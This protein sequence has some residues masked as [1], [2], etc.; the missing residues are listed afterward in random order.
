[1]NAKR[2]R[3]ALT[4]PGAETNNGDGAEDN[5]ADGYG[6]R[7]IYT[8]RS[9]RKLT[10]RLLMTLLFEHGVSEDEFRVWLDISVDDFAALNPR[11]RYETFKAQLLDYLQTGR[12]Q[13]NE[14]KGAIRAIHAREDFA[15]RAI[16]RQR[17]AGFDGW[18]R[19]A[20]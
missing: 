18:R 2:K 10:K 14:I 11:L 13:P 1:M 7:W 15:R 9:K 4:G 16:Q 6:M 5:T 8:G 19:D 17:S 3:P 12:L 20:A